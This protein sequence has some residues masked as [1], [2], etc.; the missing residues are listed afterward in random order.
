MNQA[1]IQ[2]KFKLLELRDIQ[3]LIE[4]RAILTNIISVFPSAK[5]VPYFA[6]KKMRWKALAEIYK[7]HSFA[8][9]WTVL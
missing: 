9:F 1:E 8:P 5:H 2:N 6:T 7:M 4:L 3:D